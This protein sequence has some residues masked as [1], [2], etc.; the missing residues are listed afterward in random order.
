MRHDVPE[1]DALA[2]PRFQVEHPLRDRLEVGLICL[3][4]RTLD[5]TWLYSDLT[6]PHWRMYLNDRDGAAIR[7][8]QTWIPLLRE[9]LYLIPA[10]VPF[11][12]RPGNGIR[13][14]YVHFDL[15]GI[16]GAAVR[17][18]FTSPRLLADEPYRLSRCHALRDQLGSGSPPSVATLLLARSVVDDALAEILA[19]PVPT[20][21]AR[22][23]PQCGTGPLAKVF[24][25]VQADPLAP[26]DN[27][28]LAKLA[29]C[30]PDHLV[31]R[32]RTVLGQ[33]P[34]RYLQEMRLA[35]AA[36]ALS[37]SDEPIDAIAER[38]GFAN[39]FGFT[40][41]FTRHFGCPPAA[42]RQRSGVER[43]QLD[44]VLAAG[45]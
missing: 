23:L 35:R 7:F 26:A 21:L 37:Y 30:T 22:F 20:A 16:P 9:R 27:R 34:A 2:A 29:G 8:R 31:R 33:T 32:F 36:Q 24:A 40:R 19:D 13:H 1:N 17:A 6:A 39:R 25:H 45:S 5:A 42:W 4:D 41:A 44:P 10:W 18:S 43:V 3:G 28:I 14:T 12:S 38:H 15:P 11:A